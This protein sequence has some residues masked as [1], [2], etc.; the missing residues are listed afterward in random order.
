MENFWIIGILMYAL[1]CAL[2]ALYAESK[3]ISWQPI[4]GIS[5]L[6]SPIIGFVVVFIIL[7]SRPNKK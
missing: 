1:F 5:I 3:Q 4:L 6:T 2:S 7:A